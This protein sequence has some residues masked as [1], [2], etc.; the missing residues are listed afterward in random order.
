MKK[1]FLL[2]LLFI[3]LSCYATS[4]SLP[5]KTTVAVDW[6]I[7]FVDSLALRVPSYMIVMDQAP[8]FLY[9]YCPV[10]NL[11]YNIINYTKIDPKYKEHIKHTA[12]FWDEKLPMTPVNN[13]KLNGKFCKSNPFNKESFI[14]S[15]RYNLDKHQYR[16]TIISTL[17]TPQISDYAKKLCRSVFAK[18][19]VDT[20]VYRDTMEVDLN[21]QRCDF[22]DLT[23][24]SYMSVN[25]QGNDAIA[26]ND[27]PTRT[28]LMLST[29]DPEKQR[30]FEEELR[31]TKLH[32]TQ[33]VKK[34]KLSASISYYS[35]KGIY[36]IY[37]ELR[38]PNKK[39]AIVGHCA[40][41][42]SFGLI[43]AMINSIELLTDQ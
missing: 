35:F 2:W 25:Y 4:D 16:I 11:Y 33:E 20:T 7:T 40:E 23:L 43:E 38:M 39:Y 34:N 3:N 9:L 36:A 19:E 17:D 28:S 32:K 18:D 1:P 30:E 27:T 5:Q 12:K 31:T 8:H 24:M 13:G 42:N 22:D 15:A 29:L 37:G 10:N 14:L 41:Q 26:L 6:K 21:W